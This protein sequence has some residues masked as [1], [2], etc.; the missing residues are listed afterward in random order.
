MIFDYKI[1]FIIPLLYIICKYYCKPKL[2][3]ILFS[4]IAFLKDASKADNILV[5]IVE[6]IVVL[7]L[8]FAL[9]SP[10]K[11]NKVIDKND[12]AY[13]ISL[14]MDVSGSMRENH[15]FEIVRD[16]L[17][18]FLKKRPHDK[19]ALSI[20]ADFAYVAVPL[21]GDKESITKLLSKVKVGVAGVSK[22]ALYEALFLSSNIFKHSSSK[23]K[24]AILLTDGIDN[25]NTIPL[26]TAL[27]RAQKYGLKVYTIGIG[28]RGD[29]DAQ[30]LKL[31]ANECNGSFFEANSIEKLKN[32]YKEI[33]SLEKSE[34]K[35][36]SYINKTYLYHYPLSLF[37]FFALILFLL[38][39][40]R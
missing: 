14:I 1:A 5:Q 28:N 33:D 34:I 27:K 3:P 37:V 12:N 26:Q 16:I 30:V 15:K 19:V 38:R 32:I 24:I 36:Q 2:S 21:T 29:Y 17:L 22:T 39:N 11:K 23:N 25:A 6:F 7:S 9:A 13:E 31:I 8:S 4:G 18:D 10:V 20:F 35:I 40:R